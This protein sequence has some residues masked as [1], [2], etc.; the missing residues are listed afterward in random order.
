MP[1]AGQRPGLD[2]R[3]FLAGAAC[4]ASSW[5]LNPRPAVGQDLLASTVTLG[6]GFTVTAGLGGNIVVLT[7]S[8]GAV[9]VDT[10]EAQHAS[11]LGRIIG[12]QT[13]G[14]DVTTVF[15]THWHLDQVGGNAMLREKGARLIAHVKT[16]AHLRTPYY[17]PDED[18]YQPPL[19]PDAQPTESFYDTGSLDVG[20]ERIDYGY[21]LEA[22][23]DG[24]IYVRFTDRNV[25][26]V[27]DAISPE[28]DP[29]L[30]WYGGGWLRIPV[31]AGH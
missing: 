5:L 11:G 29:V 26:A 8:S 14:A 12:S 10:G 3:S 13:G 7:T 17:L 2:R 30:D 9:V 4:A 1:I 19:P 15:N 23:T 31:H 20:G 27:G 18:R 16:L 22:H 6:E 24:D 21:L 28:R 25:I